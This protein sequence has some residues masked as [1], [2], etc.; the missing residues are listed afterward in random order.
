MSVQRCKEEL[1]ACFQQLIR[2]KRSD[3]FDGYPRVDAQIA[4]CRGVCL[5]LLIHINDPR[6]LIHTI[7]EP[8]QQAILDVLEKL[9]VALRQLQDA[10]FLAWENWESAIMQDTLRCSYLA[11]ALWRFAEAFA[12]WQGDIAH[13]G[14]ALDCEDQII[15]M[16][17]HLDRCNSITTT[18]CEMAQVLV[19]VLLEEYPFP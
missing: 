2:L 9:H 15:T 6:S 3:L 18:T 19:D 16:H 8:R 17:V 10:F 7:A 4:Q 5:D 13:G 12:K 1:H 14:E 11:G